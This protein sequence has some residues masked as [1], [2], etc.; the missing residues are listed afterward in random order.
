MEKL[1]LG[2]ACDV[3][4]DFQPQPWKEGL[5]ADPDERGDVPRVLVLDLEE[6]SS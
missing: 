4:A 6:E 3:D 2:C 1:E 5:Y